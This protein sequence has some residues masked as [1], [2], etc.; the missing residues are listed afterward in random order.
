MEFCARKEPIN[1]LSQLIKT[2]RINILIYMRFEQNNFNNSVD[3]S[4]F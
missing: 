2:H 3:I 4:L 1:I